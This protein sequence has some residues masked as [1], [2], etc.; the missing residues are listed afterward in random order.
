[1]HYL[2]NLCDTFSSHSAVIHYSL[3]SAFRGTTYWR[4]LNIAPKVIEINCKLDIFGRFQ[5]NFSLSQWKF[6]FIYDAALASSGFLGVLWFCNK[7][8]HNRYRQRY[9]CLL[10]HKLKCINEMPKLFTSIWAKWHPFLQKAIYLLDS[11]GIEVI[12]L[13]LCLSTLSGNK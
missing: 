13:V 2:N 7:L 10:C 6:M 9:R 8:F 1:M 12:Y 5:R 4:K 11:S 3:L